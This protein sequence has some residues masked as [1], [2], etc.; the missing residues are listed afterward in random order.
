LSFFLLSVNII[1]NIYEVW[2]LQFK[3]TLPIGVGKI[4]LVEIHME[5]V[6]GKRLRD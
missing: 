5:V 2:G 3:F 4:E 1:S 6:L